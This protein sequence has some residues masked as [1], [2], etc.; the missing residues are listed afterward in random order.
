MAK[1]E[2]VKCPHCDGRGYNL[3]GSNAPAVVPPESDKVPCIL[4]GGTGMLE[5]PQ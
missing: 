5:E 4:C 2:K 3:M 1:P